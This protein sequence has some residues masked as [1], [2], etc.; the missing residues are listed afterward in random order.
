M[1]CYYSFLHQESV[2]HTWPTRSSN[3]LHRLARRNR[4]SRKLNVHATSRAAILRE[5]NIN[6]AVSDLAKG[7]LT[8]IKAAV[9]PTKNPSARYYKRRSDGAWD[10]ASNKLLVCHTGT[11]RVCVDLAPASYGELTIGD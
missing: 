3:L 2:T 10:C 1:S 5:D 8:I 6:R 9:E 11:C 4:I 7:R